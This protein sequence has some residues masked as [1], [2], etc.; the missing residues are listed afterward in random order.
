MS[1]KRVK[2][3]SKHLTRGPINKLEKALLLIFFKHCYYINK[4]GCFPSD[5]KNIINFVLSFYTQR[6]RMRNRE[7]IF[8]PRRYN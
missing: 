2:N 1:K 4:S 3:P 8:T 6:K 5:R 7:F